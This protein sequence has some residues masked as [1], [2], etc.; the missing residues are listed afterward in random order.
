MLHRNTRRKARSTGIVFLVV[1]G[2]AT[3]EV[4]AGRFWPELEAGRALWGGDARA[5]G[6]GDARA[7]AGGD[8]TGGGCSPPADGGDAARRARRRRRTSSGSSGFIVLCLLNGQM[9]LWA[10]ERPLSCCGR[11]SSLLLSLTHREIRLPA[12]LGAA[13]AVLGPVVWAPRAARSRHKAARTVLG[14]R[15]SP[16]RGAS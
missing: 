3:G 11:W 14:R 7:L 13:T 4:W 6:G 1:V 12:A 16:R 2:D 15:K 8:I 10:L 9:V 5:L